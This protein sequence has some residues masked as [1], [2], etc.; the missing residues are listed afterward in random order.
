MPLS[1]DHSSYKDAAIEDMLGN[2]PGWLLRAGIGG[3]TLV[4][5]LVL[6]LTA[7]IRY[8]DKLAAPFLLQTRTV[9]LSL[10]VS[11]GDIIDTLFFSSGSWVDRGDTLLL[12]RSDGD[13][14]P[15][16]SI[17]I[18]LEG[19]AVA[20]AS[21]VGGRSS[22]LGGLLTLYAPPQ[23]VGNCPEGVQ[24]ALSAVHASWQAY[25]SYLLTNGT[26]EEVAAYELEIRKAEQLSLSIQR[27]V[28]LYEKEL[29]LQH[30]Q[31]AR[32]EQLAAE[33]IVSAQE[34]EQAS[35]QLISSERQQE[36]LVSS[37]IQN[38]LRV[39]QLRQQ[40]LQ[41]RLTHR[42][43]LSE[44]EREL[45]RQINALRS[46]INVY[47]NR[48]V[49]VAQEAGRVSW[50]SWVREDAVAPSAA[51][52][53]FLMPA[54]GDQEI[55]ARLELPVEAQGRSSVGDRVLLDFA[56]YP[57]REYGQVEG[58]LTEIDPIAL[59][60]QNKGY[61]RQATVALPNSLQTSYGK[62]LDFQYNLS[63]TAQIITVERTLLE[64]LLEQLISLFKNT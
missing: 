8:P 15:L 1:N 23:T 46:A 37:D 6:G 64:R 4:F 25:E 39:N 10:H 63:G 33:R 16:R 52:L 38:Q 21:A 29:A 34:A 5:L 36:A 26:E 27:Q 12:L 58:I 49:V 48:Y 19:L 2:P 56:G 50:Q 31:T 17:S 51:P 61:M 7:F 53:G 59:L 28:A 42:E 22:K 30:R 3:I 44:F 41:G 9:P 57:S 13:W 55:I 43:R 54:H 35:A 24:S 45:E 14:K 47:K 40:I 11:P 60:D 32:T 20:S 18:W 62:Q